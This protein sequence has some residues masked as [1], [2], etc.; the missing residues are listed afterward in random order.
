MRGETRSCHYIGYSLWLAARILYASPTEKIARNHGLCYSSRW[1][2]PGSRNSSMGPPWG[3]DPTTHRTMNG[4]PATAAPTNTCFEL[5]QGSTNQG[6]CYTSVWST[7]WNKKL[8]NRSTIRV[9]SDVP[10]YHEQPLYHGAA[11]R[12]LKTLKQEQTTG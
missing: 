1:A 10:S 8:I 4:R 11:F 9:R 3:L 12:S 7:G 5:Q 2:L 6:F